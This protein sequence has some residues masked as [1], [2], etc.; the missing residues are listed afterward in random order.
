MASLRKRKALSVKELNEIIT[1]W[2]SDDSSVSESEDNISACVSEPEIEADDFE[3]NDRVQTPNVAVP[4][5][6]HDVFRWE[7][8]EGFFPH[9]FPFDNTHSGLTGELVLPDNPT[10]SDVFKLLFDSDLVEHIATES[11][12]YHTYITNRFD[13][14]KK[15]KLNQW[16]KPTVSEIYTFLAVILLMPH[17]A[18]NRV[19]DYW[20]TDPI[21]STPI[22][23][24]IFTQDRFLLLLRLLH[25]CDPY[26]QLAGDRL[27]KISVILETTRM[28]FKTVLRPQQNL[29]IDES[30]MVWK[31]R[32][33]FKQFIPSKRHRFGVKLFVLCDCAT[34]YI[35]DF[36][37][38]TGAQTNIEVIDDLGISGS[39]VTTLLEPYLGHGH[40]VYTDNWYSSPK[41]F[42]FLLAKQTGACGTVRANRK[43]M[44]KFPQKLKKGDCSVF[45]THGILTEKWHDKRDVCMLSTVHAHE[46]VETDKIDR[47]TGEN[48]KKPLSVV[49]YNKNMGLVDKADMQ[50][51][52]LDSS[53]KSIK[54]YKK[55]FFHIL[56]I[57]VLNAHILYNIQTGKKIQLLQFRLN[58]VRQLLE[59]FSPTRNPSKGGRR[60]ANMTPS[61][62]RLSARHFPSPVP[63]TATKSK[64]QRQCYV[65]KHTTKGKKH[66]KDSRWMCVECDVALCIFPCF[67][68]F[69]SVKNF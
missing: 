46:W 6:I 69:H 3:D 50:M 45:H 24:K 60:S 25:F 14:K 17:T 51:S 68:T 8:N 44:P 47:T 56:D 16:V 31:G 53:R 52:F 26:S 32:L 1:N 62:L 59:E 9:N 54:W 40:V 13:V 37:V 57:T 55:L 28:K 21:L 12:K 61:P 20:S 23:R 49:E 2:E 39:V 66:R 65:C 10:E 64:P 33:A 30:I 29:C 36:I 43:N 7:Q 67:T 5:S 4:P 22:F 18:K 63:S 15:S 42:E 48:V 58:L 27:C 19:K 35:L 34:G 41:L 38:Y 11:D